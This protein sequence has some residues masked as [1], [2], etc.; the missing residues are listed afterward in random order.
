MAYVYRNGQRL[1]PWMAYCI[2]RFSDALHQKFGC[3]V[4]VTSGIRTY[5]EQVAIFLRRYVLAHEIRGRRVYDTRVWNGKR[6]Y[7]IDATGTVRQP[8][9]SNHE[10]QGQRGAADL[11][12]TGKDAGIMSANNP[13]S[14]WARAN[15]HKYGLVPE[16]YNFRE[17]WHFAIDG[18]FRTPPAPPTNGGESKPKTP[19]NK[20]VTPEEDEDDMPKNS[21]VWYKKDKST[22]VYLVFNAGS[23]WAHEF[24]NGTNA[25][26]MPGAYTAGLKVALDIAGWSEVTAGHAA[27]IKSACIAVRPKD[28]PRE[29]EVTVVSPE[30]L[31]NVK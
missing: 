16:G 15:A 23:G 11:R 2:D 27:V 1:T 20:P 22:Y 10:V 6:Y 24:S 17:P 5:Q 30:E 9:Y 14:N 4:V 3:R 31:A 13:R 25:G 21:G 8:G 18:I 7:R 28:A 26:T 29:I 19:T 12:D